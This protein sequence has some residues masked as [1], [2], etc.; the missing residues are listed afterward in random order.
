MPIVVEHSAAPGAV[1][2]A[3]YAAGRG[4]A[5]QRYIDNVMPMIQQDRQYRYDT[6]RRQQEHQWQ[7]QSD[8][9]RYI[10]Q[11]AMQAADHGMQREMMNRRL[12]HDESQAAADRD[13]Q[14]QQQQRGIDQGLMG[15]QYGEMI[16]GIELSL[17]GKEFT[18]VGQKL[19]N[20]L[21]GELMGIRAQQGQLRPGQYNDLLRQWKQKYDQSGLDSHI[22][23]PPAP[24]DVFKGNTYR[25]PETGTLYRITN[26]N[27]ERGI[28]PVEERNNVDAYAKAYREMED[29]IIAVRTKTAAIDPKTGR[30]VPIEP[31]KPEEVQ[32]QMIAFGYSFPQLS[33]RRQPPGAE[34]EGGAAP[35]TA[36]VAPQPPTPQ[37]P[38]P[39]PNTDAMAQAVEQAVQAVRD[40]ANGG[41]PAASP[42]DRR[43]NG[44]IVAEPHRTGDPGAVVVPAFKDDMYRVD[45]NAPKLGPNAAGTG[46]QGWTPPAG[47]LKPQSEFE[48]N[49]DD[50]QHQAEMQYWE[51]RGRQER[52]FQ[53]VVPLQLPEP[54][55]KAVEGMPQITPEQLKKPLSPPPKGQKPQHGGV[56]AIDNKEGMPVLARWD[57]KKG[58]YVVVAYDQRRDRENMTGWSN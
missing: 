28:E 9:S 43:R 12:S 46:R 26:R 5:Q 42:E 35:A 17:K 25:D 20:D 51:E 27:G 54:V 22:V 1:G 50:A 2:M 31:P 15:D 41:A 13:F 52:E 29:Q 44:E 45:P 6:H 39:A 37:P 36:P 18:P 16:R 24:E 10:Q 57:E 40:E 49:V 33:G 34:A 55:A 3:A 19:H 38:P 23:Q 47:I 11:M 58:K 53:P 30:A 8:R 48:E 7:V 21:M 14:Q 32:D 56:Y 4:R